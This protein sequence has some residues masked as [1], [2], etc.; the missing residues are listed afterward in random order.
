MEMDHPVRPLD[1]VV[2]IA[3]AYEPARWSFWQRRAHL[4]DGSYVRAVQRLGGITILLPV[5]PRHPLDWLLDLIDGLLVIGGADVDPS[6]YGA[7]RDPA[8][9]ANYPDRDR[10]EIDLIHGALERAIPILGICRGMHILNVAL[11]GTLAQDLTGADGTTIHRRQ[12]GR[13]EGTEQEIALDEGSLVATAACE[14]A[15]TAYCHHHQAVDE[16]GEGL[17]VSGRATADGLPEAIEARDGRWVLGVQWHPEAEDDSTV[18]AAFV[19]A[20]RERR[21]LAVGEG[22]PAR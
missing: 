8:T 1:P 17:L 10:F 4:V 2:G 19:A 3:A 11:G 7:E 15:H 5:D 6:V 21:W 14:R 20:A 9:E 12:L 16:L 13:F 22:D 18:L